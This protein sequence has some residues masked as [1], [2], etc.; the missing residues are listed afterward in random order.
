MGY[1][2]FPKIIHQSIAGLYHFGH[3]NC[4]SRNPD[5]NTGTARSILSKHENSF[6]VLFS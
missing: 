6:H 4:P 3:L 1:T 2:F 5:P